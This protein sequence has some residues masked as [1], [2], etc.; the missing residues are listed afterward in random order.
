MHSTRSRNAG[1]PPPGS[2]RRTST[3]TSSAGRCWPTATAGGTAREVPPAPPLASS[4][5]LL[6]AA[7]VLAGLPA[8]VLGLSHA[9]RERDRAEILSREARSTI[10][11]MLAQLSDRHEMDAPDCSR[12]ARHSSNRRCTTTRTPATGP[13]PTSNLAESAEAQKH[14]AQI[15]RLLG[16]HD[17]AAWQYQEALSRFEALAAT[18]PGDV[19]FQDDRTEILTELGELLLPVADRRAEARQYL[20]QALRQ[21]EA[22]LTARPKSTA[23]RRDLARVVGDFGPA[24]AG[25]GPPR[26]GPVP[27][28]AR[29]R[30]PRRP[31]L[32]ASRQ[33]GR[34]DQPGLGPGGPG[35][36]AGHES[37]HARPGGASLHARASNFAR[38]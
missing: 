12:P 34:R 35:T 28:E 31:G 11:G 27:V 24:R 30:P 14:I 23:T 5:G 3:G 22:D 1:T 29:D 26:S 20:E 38:R 25:R 15:N 18:D 8:L 13:A 7:L 33:P 10:D 36:G 9:R 16:L 32:R 4:A 19:R 2:S 17:V 6:L 37:G 21:L